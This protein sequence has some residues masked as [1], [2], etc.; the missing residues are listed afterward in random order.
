MI[1]IDIL[2]EKP[3]KGLEKFVDEFYN[4]RI[5]ELGQLQDSFKRLDY[6][7]I[8]GLAH[9]WKGFSQPYG[10]DALASLSEDLEESSLAH[11]QERSRQLIASIAKYLENKG[12][13]LK[14][15]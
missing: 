5:A 6:D 12:K 15:V 7:F 9:K 2:N 8:R 13:L 14:L 3:Q 4:D 10:F 11:D 1:N